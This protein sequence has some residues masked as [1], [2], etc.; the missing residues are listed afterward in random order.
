MIIETSVPENRRAAIFFSIESPSPGAF[1]ISL[2][3]RGRERCA[4]SL[5]KCTD[6][7]RPIL[8]MDLKLDDLLER[9]RE[10]ALDLDL[11]YVKLS[12][13]RTLDLLRKQFKR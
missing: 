10:D 2:L 8:T 1:I 13:P 6:R 3:Y 9:K 12:V 5:R 4:D 11:E 7:F